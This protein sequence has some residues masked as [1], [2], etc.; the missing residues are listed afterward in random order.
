LEI[1]L[2]PSQ[3][4]QKMLEHFQKHV[5]QRFDHDRSGFYVA[6]GAEGDRLGFV[7]LLPDKNFFTGEDVARIGDLIVVPEAEGQGIGHALIEFSEE[8]ARSKGFGTLILAVFA[9]NAR[10]RNLYA[11]V[12]FEEELVRMVKSL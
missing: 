2:L 4:P 9:A 5:S 8:W 12:G 3:D 11:R 7:S 1:N 6:C 10:A